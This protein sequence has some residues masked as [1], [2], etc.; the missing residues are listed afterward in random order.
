MDLEKV[1]AVMSWER[2]KLVFEIRSFLGLEG[3]Y[4][5]FI[6]DFSLLAEPMARLPKK[7]SSSSG[8]TCAR[9]HSKS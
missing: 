2:P 4:R 1:E 8:M 6:E 9:R 5:R 7:R 3:Y